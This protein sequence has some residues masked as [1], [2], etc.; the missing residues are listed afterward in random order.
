MT[1][2]QVSSFY[3]WQILELKPSQLVQLSPLKKQYFTSII[4]SNSFNIKTWDGKIKSC[5][6]EAGHII[7]DFNSDFFKDFIISMEVFN[8][9]HVTGITKLNITGNIT[10]VENIQYIYSWLRSVLGGASAE[11]VMKYPYSYRRNGH[12][13]APNIKI[14]HE[15]LV[16]KRRQISNLDFQILI[17]QLKKDSI[18][19]I[20]DN[21]I[22]FSKII[23]ICSI[24]SKVTKE[25]I[26]YIFKY[27]SLPVIVENIKSQIQQRIDN[28]DWNEINSFD[29]QSIKKVLVNAKDNFVG[30]EWLL[31]LACVI[32]VSMGFGFVYNKPFSLKSQ[33]DK[34][35]AENNLENLTELVTIERQFHQTELNMKTVSLINN[36]SNEDLVQHQKEIEQEIKH[37]KGEIIPLLQDEIISINNVDFANQ[38]SISEHSRLLFT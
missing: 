24:F 35:I 1:K 29:L 34:T 20:E 36:V 6:H 15:M 4:N 14:V 37:H 16:I 8:R 11:I 26:E 21:K 7:N 10:D 5:I 22:A 19:V 38:H 9:E 31:F 2:Q 23:E 33:I 17:E 3:L 13:V 12:E 28:I 25:E 27:K 32:F 18:K 30:N